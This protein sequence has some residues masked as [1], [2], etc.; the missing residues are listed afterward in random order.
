[1]ALCPF[2][3]QLPINGTGQSY[4]G[5]PFRIVHHTTE[6]SNASGAFSAYRAQLE[7]PHFTIEGPTIFQH[8]DTGVS[9]FSLKHTG[10]PQTN[11]LSAI[12][13]EVVGFFSHSKSLTTLLSIA[14][15]CRWI[16]ETHDVPKVWPN[17]FPVRTPD[18]SP[19]DPARN[20]ANWIAKG[21]HYGHCHVPENDHF[22][23]GYSPAEVHIIMQDVAVV[24]NG[25]TILEAGG[26]MSDT[27]HVQAWIRPIANA[28]G[29]EITD[30][31]ASSIT[32]E[33]GTVSLPL[34]A[35]VRDGYAFAPLGLLSGLP[36]VTVAYDDAARKLSITS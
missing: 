18:P 6:G 24:V 5:G 25:E 36:N 2:A 4:V 20:V 15:L 19:T 27:G 13:I 12:Q 35:D 11:R 3:R 10:S 1:M 34:P 33:K 9:S 28:I 29:A 21:G 32:L 31:G 22:D 30:V 16:E 14:K 23:P 17:G 26:Y 7:E 8:L